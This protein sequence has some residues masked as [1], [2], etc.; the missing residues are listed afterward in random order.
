VDDYLRFYALDF[1]P[2]EGRGRRQWEAE[3]RPR[4]LRPKF[5]DVQLEDLNILSL[6]AT[7]ATV[8]FRQLYRS[9]VVAVAATK[10][11]KLARE[12]GDW[13][14]LEESIQD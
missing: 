9:D 7:E 5:I 1:R 2:P 4:I 8:K 14:I 6:D 3:R 12:R 11:L 13:K 10:V